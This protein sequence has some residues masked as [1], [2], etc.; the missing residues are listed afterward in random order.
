LNIPHDELLLLIPRDQNAEKTLELCLA[1]MKRTP[2]WLPGLPLDAEG[3][4][5][6]RYS[7]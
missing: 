6:D 7:K 1:E 4:L 2:D 3:E 5:G